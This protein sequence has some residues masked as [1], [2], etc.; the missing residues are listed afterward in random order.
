MTTLIFS[1]LLQ[2]CLTLDHWTNQRRGFV[3]CAAHWYDKLKMKHAW[4]RSEWL[5]TILI[6]DAVNNT[7]SNFIKAFVEFPSGSETSD[8]DQS[9]TVDDIDQLQPSSLTEILN[10]ADEVIS[11][12]SLPTHLCCVTYRLN[13]IGA[14]DA[15]ESLENPICKR[16]YR[17]TGKLF[18]KQNRSTLVS[19]KIKQK[20]GRL[21]VVHNATR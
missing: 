16:V 20:L 9:I 12:F 5:Q 15:T 6:D 4:W 19:D 21:F 18:N 7:S 13:R 2:V 1:Y 8:Q 11:Q 14:K 17:S 3:G 10:S